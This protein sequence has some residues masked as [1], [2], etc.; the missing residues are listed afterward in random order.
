MLSVVLQIIQ[1]ITLVLAYGGA[2]LGVFCLIDAVTRRPDAFVAADKKTKGTWIAIT[3]GSAV[4][5]GL[6]LVSPA[7]EP[8]SIFWL[9]AMIGVLVYLVDVRP[10][11]K[12]V[13][14]PQRW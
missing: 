11:L 1:A 6:A 3:A 2:V 5:L 7:F 10:R 13:S 4:V 8:Q 9:A 14:G 12:E